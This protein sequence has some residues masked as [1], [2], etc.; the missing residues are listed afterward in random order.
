MTRPFATVNVD[1]DPV[2][3]HLLGYGVRGL[4][5]DPL[6]YD[7][8]LPRLLQHCA[9][10]GVRATFFCVGR[11]APAHAA[12]I[13]SIAAAGHEVASHSL[14]HPLALTRLPAEA[15]RREVVESKHRLEHS[16]G[17]AVTG[18]R[19]PNFDV[20]ARVLGAVAA[21]GYRY[22]ASGYPTP[23]LA[24]ARLVLALKGGDPA[25]VMRMRLAPHSL[26]R[27]PRRPGTP[28][29]LASFPLSV[30][31]FAR[32]PVYHTLRLLGGPGPTR[33]RME[34]FA[35]RGEPLSYTLHAVDA[36]GLAE[37]AVDPRLVRHPGMRLPLAE[38][39]LALDQVLGLVAARFEA[40]TFQD[41]MARMELA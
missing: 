15:L 2:D 31:P 41:R 22:D 27:R 9:R 13:G 6:V 7:V 8:A 3:V 23:L 33:R 14:T 39:L 24:A 28:G 40:T 38:K 36:L 17:R 25:S 30:T 29:S 20:D 32:W 37:D 10:A 26:E 16:T 4:A 35:R 12:A 19:A 5:P 11:D 18:F 1:V 34:G 21:A